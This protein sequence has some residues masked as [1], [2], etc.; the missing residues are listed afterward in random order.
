MTN[1]KLPLLLVPGFMLDDSL[2]DELLAPLSADRDVYLANLKSGQTIAE[3]AQQIALKAPARFVLIGCS[4]GGYIARSLVE[5][6]PER[7]AALILIASS[8]RED[9]PEQKRYKEQAV[10]ATNASN[11][12]GL[13]TGTIAKSLH[14]NRASDK[15]LIARLQHIGAQLGYGEFAK[16][17][18]LDRS[19]LLAEKIR[20][21][22][23]VIAADQDGLR[24]AEEAQELSQSIKGAQLKVVQDT[25]HMIPLEQPQAL[26]IIIAQWL[27]ENS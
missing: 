8:L 19:G 21:P 14:P 20:C 26:A 6:F 23:L 27:Q 11:F 9:T 5:Q 7:V 15:P 24:S 4:L 18:L 16:Q 3:I 1:A 13:S 10:R 17:S 12:R 22:T 25:G 2:W